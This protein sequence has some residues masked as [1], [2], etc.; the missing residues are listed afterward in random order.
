[1]ADTDS[2]GIPD[3]TKLREKFEQ[4]YENWAKAL[5]E[6]QLI[7]TESLSLSGLRP[8]LKSRVKSFDSWYAKKIRY[9]K[10]AY[11][12]K[13]SEL[14]INDVLAIRVVCPFLGDLAIVE[15][16]LSN[17]FSV[18]E[19]ERKGAERSYKEFGYESIHMLVEI[20]ENL[21]GLCGGMESNVIE[22]Q[23]RT[24]LQEAWAEIEHELV[25]KAEFDFFDEAMKRK[26]AALNA[27]LTLSDIIFQEILSY[28]KRLASELEKRRRT[29]YKKIEDVEDMPELARPD[30]EPGSPKMSESEY[31]GDDGGRLKELDLSGSDMDTLLLSALECHNAADF[32]GAIAIYT[33]IIGKN[34]DDSVKAV[35]YKHRGMAKFAQSKYEEAIEDF[36]SCLKLDPDSHKA[37]YYRGVTKAV[38]LDLHGALDDFSRVL[39]MHPYHFFARYRRALCW[40]RLGDFAAAHFD[41]EIA[42]RIEPENQ[43]A[44][45]LMNRIKNK[46]AKEDF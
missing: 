34:P 40:Y 36:S 3:K 18:V 41:G 17:R 2:M 27:N 20:P 43:L 25:Y 19:I 35:V 8:T 29:F 14:P 10:K 1:M 37:M 12:E 26:L 24:I 21:C 46:L 38:L 15:R 28:E 30:I 32:A 7:I 31:K 6:F 42:L 11:T 33:R 39:D 9:L 45:R 44:L 5:A 13:G 16:M 22:I 23:L 4:N